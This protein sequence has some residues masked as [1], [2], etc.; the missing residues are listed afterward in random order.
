MRAASMGA[1]FQNS[2]ITRSPT[3]PVFDSVSFSNPREK[4]VCVRSLHPRCSTA[5][6]IKTEAC[7]PFQCNLHFAQENIVRSDLCQGERVL[8]ARTTNVRTFREQCLKGVRFRVKS[9]VIFGNMCTRGG[10]SLLS[11]FRVGMEI[12]CSQN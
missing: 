8:L 5:R 3:P 2:T 6:G 7:L 4:N 1:L 12:I 10:K 9:S 11:Y